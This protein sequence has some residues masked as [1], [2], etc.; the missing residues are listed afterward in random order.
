[1]SRRL[2]HAFHAFVVGI[3]EAESMRG[4]SASRVPPAVVSRAPR[5]LLEQPAWRRAQDGALRAQKRDPVGAHLAVDKSLSSAGLV[6]KR[7]CLLVWAEHC[8]QVGIS[9]EF[10]PI[11]SKLGD[12]PQIACGSIF[13]QFSDKAGIGLMDSVQCRIFLSRQN[14]CRQFKKLEILAL[15]ADILPIL[16]CKRVFLED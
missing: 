7:L 15:I 4:L 14:S 11:L 6:N 5:S 8:R 1:M 9:W 12:H 13:S 10:L 3:C 2:D 16:I